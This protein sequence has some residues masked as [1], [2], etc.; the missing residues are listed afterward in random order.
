MGCGLSL[1]RAPA[2]TLARAPPATSIDADLLA[3]PPQTSRGVHA[4]YRVSNTLLGKGSFGAVWLGHNRVT[5]EA[6]AIKLLPRTL[7]AASLAREY[8]VLS[9][10]LAP[11]PAVVEFIAG[12]STRSEVQ[13]VTALCSGGELFDRILEQG[14]LPE[15]VAAIGIAQIASGLCWLHE[16]GIIHRD[17]KPENIMISST[18]APEL[19]Q[20]GDFGLAELCLPGQRLSKSCGTWAYAAPEM[21][22]HDYS[23]GFDL[24]S[25]G[26]LAYVVL[27][28]LHPFDPEG[29]SPPHDIRARARAGAFSFDAPEC[30]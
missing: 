15:G 23:H 3:L 4:D 24:W 2:P 18:E 21:Q 11:H 28:G 6:V 25:L 12:Y 1:P 16:R 14:P 19:W 7:K 5:G 8:R 17:I 30:R 10:L 27:V 20:I 26:V 22:S 9:T 29:R 13:L